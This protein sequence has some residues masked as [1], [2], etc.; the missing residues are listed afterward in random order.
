MIVQR[1]DYYFTVAFLF[2]GTAVGFCSVSLSEEVERGQGVVHKFRD[3]DNIDWSSAPLTWHSL[4]K[5]QNPEVVICDRQD[6]DDDVDADV[7]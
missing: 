7:I 6:D 1:I 4:V 5:P 3:N 2:P